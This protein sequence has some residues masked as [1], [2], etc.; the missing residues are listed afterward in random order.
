MLLDGSGLDDINS[1]LQFY[2]NVNV[3]QGSP[4]DYTDGKHNIATPDVSFEYLEYV[5]FGLDPINVNVI[6]DNMAK[7]FMIMTV[8]FLLLLLPLPSS[9]LLP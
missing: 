9:F 2:S 3:Y 6:F 7:M 8:P 4:N 1:D 5:D